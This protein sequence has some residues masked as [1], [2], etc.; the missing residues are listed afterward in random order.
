[1]RNVVLFFLLISASVF[2]QDTSNDSLGYFEKNP[3]A[4][5]FLVHYHYLSEPWGQ[6]FRTGGMQLSLGFN[7]MCFFTNKFILGFCFDFKGIKGFT[8]QNLGSPFQHEFKADFIDV[9]NDPSDSAKAHFVA[10]TV[11]SNGFSGNYSGNI[12]IAIAP[13]PQK[14]GGFLLI[15]KR[16]YRQYPIF[17]TYGNKYI[18]GGTADNVTIDV[19]NVYSAELL[20]KPY[21]F[22]RRSSLD[23]GNRYVSF[24]KGDLNPL[25]FITIGFVAERIDIRTATF[26]NMALNRM[27]NPAFMNKYGVC[28]RFGC[29]V[30]V[31]LY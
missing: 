13:F 15:V 11:S 18:S 31:S 30:G 23:F 17:G 6:G 12:G 16:G 10:N 28:W 19:K 24:R 20:M 1:M 22:F 29:K 25:Q 2:A 7:P 8:G 9:Y 26:D 4:S 21:T 14:Y 27:V 5:P 3:Q